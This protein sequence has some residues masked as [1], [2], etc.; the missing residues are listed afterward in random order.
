MGFF[1]KLFGGSEVPDEITD[2]I[3]INEKYGLKPYIKG[4]ISTLLN[5]TSYQEKFKKL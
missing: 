4:E 1:K 5:E 2:P 3:D